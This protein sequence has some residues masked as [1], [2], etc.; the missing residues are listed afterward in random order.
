MAVTTRTFGKRD[1]RI[2]ELVFGGAPIG[3][4]YAQVSDEQAAG[5]LEAAWDAGIRAFDTAPH[6]GVGLS[7]QRIGAFLAGRPRGE[8]VLSTKVGRRLVPAAGPVDGADEFYG[9][10]QLTRVRDYSRDGV[11]ATLEDSMRRLGVDRVD[12]ALI[13]D[14]DDHAEE[15][16][17]GAYAAL[18]ELRSQ[19][20]VGAVGVGMNQT[21]VLE[22]F[23]ERADLDCVLVAG[24]YSL[25]DTQAA[26]RLFPACQRRGV[27]V[28]AAGIF[29]SGILADPRPGAT[30]DYAPAP[31]D[32]VE[33]AQR[34][35]AVCARHGVPLGAA[36]TRF[37]LRHPAVTAVVVGARS[38]EE[39]T[40]DAGYLDAALPDGLFAELA[41]D[42]LIP[43]QR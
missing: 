19:G 15:A 20:T 5:A 41:A 32:L 39:I 6:Y 7:E 30:Y 24:R 34:I 25:L 10:P 16:L 36:A 38:A 4:L 9:T 8:F 26:D 31:A 43:G 33:R 35:R 3:G 13:H 23:V 2:S 11:L 42:G 22:W 28:L 40:E 17:D 14:P 21:P 37:V 29:N 27:A 12:I 18:D 1:L